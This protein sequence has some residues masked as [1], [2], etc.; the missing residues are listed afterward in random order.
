MKHKRFTHSLSVLTALAALM[1]AVAPSQAAD[2]KP[3]VL[4]IMGDDVGLSL[5][6]I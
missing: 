1:C 4:F 2:K 5:I 6:H 3:N